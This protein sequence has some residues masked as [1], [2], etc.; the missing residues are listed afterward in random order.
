M[1]KGAEP[2]GSTIIEIDKEKDLDKLDIEIPVLSPSI[3]REYKNLEELN[4]DNFEFNPAELKEFSPEEQK[5]ILFREI[6]D[7]YAI[8]HNVIFFSF[9]FNVFSS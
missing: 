3:I 7:A 9:N 2:A 1:G 8:Y 6:I 4:V 5:N